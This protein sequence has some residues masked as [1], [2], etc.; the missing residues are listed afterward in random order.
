MRSPWLPG[1][2]LELAMLLAACTGDDIGPSNTPPIAAFTPAC[3]LLACTFADGSTDPDGQITAYAWTFGDGTA[4]ATTENPQHT[5]AAA[6]TYIVGL[7]VTD[8]DGVATTVTRPVQVGPPANAPPTAGFTQACTAL[9]CDF[10]DHSADRDGTVVSFHWEFGDGSEATTRHSA[11]AYAS[12]GAY[13]V[14]LTVTDDRGATGT[15]AQTVV[16]TAPQAGGPTA[17]FTGSCVIT[18]HIGRSFLVGCTFTDLSTGTDGAAITAWAWNFGDGITSTEQTPRR[19]GYIIPYRPG[20][21]PSV[22]VSLRVTDR[23]GLSNEVRQS[24]VVHVALPV[25]SVP[26]ARIRLPCGAAIAS[27]SARSARPRPA[28]SAS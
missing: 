27:W 5:F 17:A 10:T 13:T 6:N 14:R 3:V 11:H 20:R 25:A 23:N 12:A 24:V 16:V 22:Q 1:L 15:L 21:L 2:A 7:T 26:G 28:G 9:A 18:G 19:H 8:D 4:V